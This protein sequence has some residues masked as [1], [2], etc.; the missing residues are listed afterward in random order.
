[1]EKKSQKPFFQM[2]FTPGEIVAARRK[3]L[4]WSQEE[5]EYRSGVSM[6][7]IY[8]IENNKSKGGEDVIKNLEEALQIPLKDVFDDY[9]KNKKPKKPGPKTDP[10]KTVIKGFIREI[11][12]KNPTVKELENIFDRVIKDL[13]DTLLDAAQKSPENTSQKQ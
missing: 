3:K 6:S 5:L 12:K 9:W 7:Q 2:E 4:G 13:D 8:R 11:N 1:M 10:R